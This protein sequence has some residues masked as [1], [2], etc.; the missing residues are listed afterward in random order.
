MKLIVQIPCFNE[1]RT[2]AGAIAEIPRAIPGVDSVEVLVIDDGSSD[3]TVEVAWQAGADHVI[4]HRAN[5]GLAAAFRTGIDGCLRYGADII[6]NTDGDNQYAGSG[7]PA[8]IRPILDGAAELVVGDRQV[9]QSPHYS[10]VKRRLHALGTK[11]IQRL[12]RTEVTDPV[13]GFRAF[14][15]DAAMLLNV[16]SPFSYTIETLIQAGSHQIA[17]ATVPI[18]TNAATRKSRLFKSIPHFV[19]N[20]LATMVRIYAMYHPLR[21]FG[22]IGIVLGLAGAIPILRFLYFYFSGNGGGHVQS[23][24]LGG[25]LVLM[26]FVAFLFAILADLVN[27][28]RRLVESTLQKV[29]RLEIELKSQQ[30]NTPETDRDQPEAAAKKSSQGTGS[31]RRIS[32]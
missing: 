16:V 8:L 32:I 9:Q 18:E 22:Y 29:R 12:S 23:L 4:R 14:S 21:L 31:T 10:P 25:V 27:F 13:S 19:M 26:G 11:V 2:L 24:I 20:S 30:A 3:A 15:R 28:N 1:E 5:K 7:I 17:V 6:V